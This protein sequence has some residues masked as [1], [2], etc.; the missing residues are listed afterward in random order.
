MSRRYNEEYRRKH[1]NY[2][3]PEVLDY[4]TEHTRCNVCGTHLKGVGWR[5]VFPDWARLFYCVTCG[6]WYRT[7]TVCTDAELERRRDKNV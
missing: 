6:K 3:K 4:C 5:C 7:S 1:S 2:T